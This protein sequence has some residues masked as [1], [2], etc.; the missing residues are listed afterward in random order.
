MLPLLDTDQLE[1]PDMVA[2]CRDIAAPAQRLW[3]VEV[4]HGLR[5]L[6]TTA[7]E[8]DEAGEEVHRHEVEVQLQ[9][10]NLTQL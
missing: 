4:E 7:V 8:G 9:G 2:K 1:R 5:V 6:I 3:V 10:W